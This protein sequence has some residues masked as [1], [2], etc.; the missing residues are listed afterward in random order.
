V[1]HRTN[2]EMTEAT[3]TLLLAEARRAFAEHGYAGAPIEEVVRAAGL[4]K[5]ALYHHFGSK[6]GLF[7]AVLRDLDREITARV[8]LD[9]AASDDPWADLLAALRVYLEATL[10]PG[11]RRI[12]LI[13]SLAVLGTTRARELDDE[14][15]AEPLAV[16]LAALRDRGLLANVE[17]DALARILTGAL[18]EAALWIADSPRP[19]QA[20]ERAMATLEQLLTGGVAVRTRR[21][22]GG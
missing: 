16:A 20:L 12:L 6:Q 8:E 5:G 21:R 15:T 2:A 3:R 1:A 4:T 13:D 18:G 9:L 17:V 7:E 14:M 19:A 22:R 11:V 10:D